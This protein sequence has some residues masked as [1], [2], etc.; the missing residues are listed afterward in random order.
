VTYLNDIPFSHFQQNGG[1]TAFMIA[2]WFGS[3]R[4]AL[5]L[6]SLGGDPG[7]DLN[8]ADDVRNTSMVV[9]YCHYLFP[10]SFSFFVQAGKTAL[11]Y[12]IIHEH[13]RDMI[14]IEIVN[15]GRAYL[16]YLDPVSCC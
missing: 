6:L 12:A 4:V 7:V 16:N 5:L 10:F 15:S 14:A 11:I 9:L 1:L 3:T 2:T 13:D 8:I